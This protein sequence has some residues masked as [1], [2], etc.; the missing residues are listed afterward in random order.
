V[1]DISN[2]IASLA[3]CL[4]RARTRICP[5]RKGINEFGDELELRSNWKF[6]GSTYIV[7]LRGCGHEQGEYYFINEAD[8]S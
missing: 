1:Y 5:W 6:S 2:T 7:K 8:S 3:P 4:E